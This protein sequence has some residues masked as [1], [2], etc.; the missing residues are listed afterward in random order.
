LAA[1]GEG[2]LTGGLQRLLVGLGADLAVTGEMDAATE[3]ALAE[4]APDA[5]ATPMDRILAVAEVHWQRSPFR[6]DLY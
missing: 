6:V 3:A 5:G 2:D 4:V 1:M